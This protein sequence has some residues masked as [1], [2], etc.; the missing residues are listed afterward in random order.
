[1]KSLPMPTACAPWPEKSKAVLVIG[2]ALLPLIG[3]HQLRLRENVLPHC[4]FNCLFCGAGFQVERSIQCIELEEIT[5]R[6][7][8][9]GARPAITKMFKIVKALLRAV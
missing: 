3:S 6:I 2:L 7:S 5:M 9:R 8:R 1:M 4:L